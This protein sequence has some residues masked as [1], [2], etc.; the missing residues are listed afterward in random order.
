M[1][2][3]PWSTA[4]SN[5]GDECN[6]KATGIGLEQESLKV[7]RGISH[8]KGKPESSITASPPPH[9]ASTNRT[10]TTARRA[11]NR[12]HRHH[13][14]FIEV[15]HAPI[16]P[17]LKPVAASL[18]KDTFNN[19]TYGGLDLNPTAGV[20]VGEIS[21]FSYHENRPPRICNYQ[22]LCLCRSSSA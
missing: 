2:S 7:H 19:D 15:H 16:R 10:T 8:A 5:P 20:L 9:P 12:G 6:P 17:N 18:N 13:M 1:T 22:Q 3:I 4:S 14:G 11:G 21:R